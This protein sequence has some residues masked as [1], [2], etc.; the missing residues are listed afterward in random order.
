MNAANPHF[1]YVWQPRLMASYF[2][3]CGSHA[4]AKAMSNEKK[5]NLTLFS[6]VGLQA[7]AKAHGQ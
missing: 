2:S 7:L 1:V 4:L 5:K 3:V 6:M